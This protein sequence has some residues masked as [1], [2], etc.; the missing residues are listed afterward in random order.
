MSTDSLRSLISLTNT[1]FDDDNSLLDL[2][3]NQD[4]LENLNEYLL[5]DNESVDE[6]GSLG[7]NEPSN[8]KSFEEEKIFFGSQFSVKQFGFIFLFLVHKMK[9]PRNQRD[10]LFRVFKY[11]LP[12][13][14]K[15]PR[16][17]LNSVINA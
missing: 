8:A 13:N 3:S 4:F 7:I 9:L 10:N 2:D 6:I 16:V 15:L 17:L 1:I 5:S 11:I 12:K 14:N